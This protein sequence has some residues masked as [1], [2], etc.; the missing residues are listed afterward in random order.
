MIFYLERLCCQGNEDTVSIYQF[1]QYW[2]V[3]CLNLEIGPT[4]LIIK[5]L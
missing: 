3:R 5:L 4:T 2:Q 1:K